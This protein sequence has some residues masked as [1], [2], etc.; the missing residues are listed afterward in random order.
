MDISWHRRDLSNPGVGQALGEGRTR[1]YRTPAANGAYCGRSFGLTS[2][3]GC[4]HRRMAWTSTTRS[5][6]SLEQCLRRWTVARRPLLEPALE[7]VLSLQSEWRHD[8]VRIRRL[9]LE[10]LAD[11]VED[12]GD[13]GVAGVPAGTDQVDVHGNTRHT[14]IPVV[15]HLLDLVVTRSSRCWYT[16]PVSLETGGMSRTG[17]PGPKP[18]STRTSWSSSRSHRL[19]EWSVLPGLEHQNDSPSGNAR[20]RQIGGTTAGTALAAASIPILHKNENGDTKVRRGEDWHRAGHNS[21]IKAHDMPT[22]RFV[23]DHVDIIRHSTG[24]GAGWSVAG[25]TSATRISAVAGEAPGALWDLPGGA[26]HSANARE[27]GQ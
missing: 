6:T 24:R 14:Q 13:G 21:T 10:E 20:R 1:A 7:W 19:A 18:A 22:H 11:M 23:E 17:R 2:F 25:A 12:M 4:K 3:Q 5:F 16:T 26:E 9:V 15:L 8:V 27:C